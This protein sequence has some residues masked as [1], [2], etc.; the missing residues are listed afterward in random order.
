MSINNSEPQEEWE[1]GSIENVKLQLDL[2]TEN[3]N[4]KLFQYL[5]D[6]R[7]FFDEQLQ[8]AGFD[9]LNRPSVR[10]IQLIENYVTGKYTML[11]TQSHSAGP[12]D[13]AKR[14]I[15]T[16]IRAQ[17][18]STTDDG[19]ATGANQFKLTEGNVRSGFGL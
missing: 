16:H 17:L 14:D 6:A 8:K 12:F 10:Q 5:H 1:S 19:V 18:Q 2:E 13:S 3:V 7:S 4:A 9:N 15:M 11:N